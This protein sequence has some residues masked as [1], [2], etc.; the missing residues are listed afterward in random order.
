MPNIQFEL[1]YLKV[2]CFY[3]GSTEY[4]YIPRPKECKGGIYYCAQCGEKITK[5]C[6]FSWKKCKECKLYV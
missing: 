6:K 1:G 3:C 4:N 2:K 5:D